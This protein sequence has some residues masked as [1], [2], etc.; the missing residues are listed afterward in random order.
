MK[1]AGDGLITVHY[2][3]FHYDPCRCCWLLLN[4]AS[5]PYP[6]L[7]ELMQLEKCSIKGMSFVDFRL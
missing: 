3:L 5:K 7:Q 2:G 1:V 6:M 4:Q